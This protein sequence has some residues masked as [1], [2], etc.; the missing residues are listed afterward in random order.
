MCGSGLSGP[1]ADHEALE[2]TVGGQPVC[3]VHTG[4]RDL[5]RREKARQ[6]GAP[7][8]IGDDTATAVVRTG[9]DGDGLTCRVDAR[10]PA[11]RGDRGEALL[12]SLDAACVE[13]NA[14]VAGLGHPCVDRRGDD[15]ARCQIS[16]GMYTLGDR[17]TL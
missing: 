16:H 17:T 5:P 10:L 9:D 12:E 4:A 2:Q 6:L 8:H 15:V 13:V 3:A 7:V 1:A 14:G 11:R